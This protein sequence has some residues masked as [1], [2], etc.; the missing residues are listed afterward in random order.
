MVNTNGK[1][2]NTT[3]KLKQINHNMNINM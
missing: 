1:S 2:K 3:Q